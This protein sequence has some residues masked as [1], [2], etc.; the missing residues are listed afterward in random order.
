M[1]IKFEIRKKHW[2]GSQAPI[3][4]AGNLQFIGKAGRVSIDR[5]VDR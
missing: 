2:P 1:K 4:K 5:N 3:Y